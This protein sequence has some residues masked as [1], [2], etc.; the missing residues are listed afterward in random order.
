MVQE[1]K[2]QNQQKRQR[3]RPAELKA[4][5]A[6]SQAA[7]ASTSA[8]KVKELSPAEALKEGGNAALKQGDL[9]KVGVSTT[10]LSHKQTRSSKMM[11]TLSVRCRARSCIPSRAQNADCS[12]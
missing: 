5:L 7:L 8:F 4:R 6:S 3:D 10:V 9:Q 11:C 2:A 12:F 1:A